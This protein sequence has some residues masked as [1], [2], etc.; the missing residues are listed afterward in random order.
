M[1]SI[2]KGNSFLM[3]NVHFHFL[4]HE[5]NCVVTNKPAHKPESLREPIAMLLIAGY[6]LYA[7]TATYN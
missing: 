1:V 2:I 7:G 3:P 5:F 6:L 4:K